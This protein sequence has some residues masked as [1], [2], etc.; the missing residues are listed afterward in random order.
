MLKKIIIGIFILISIFYCDIS[1]GNILDKLIEFN[2]LVTIAQKY[3]HVPMNPIHIKIVVDLSY[4]YGIDPDLVLA[5]IEVESNYNYLAKNKN[6]SARGYSQ[7]IKSTALSLIDELNISDY[8]HS[9]DSYDPNINLQLM[10]YYL[11]KCINSS[12][13]LESTLRKY[14][15]CNDKAYFKKVLKIRNRIKTIKERKSMNE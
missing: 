10:I 4:Q 14:R 5:I 2:R 8:N 13:T 11:Y 7:M 6:S 1:D 15:G 9:I 12:N 3:D